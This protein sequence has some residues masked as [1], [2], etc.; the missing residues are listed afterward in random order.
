MSSANFR[1]QV[2]FGIGASEVPAPDVEDCELFHEDLFHKKLLDLA[3]HPF[4]TTCCP[5][6]ATMATMLKMHVYLHSPQYGYM[7]AY[8]VQ[9]VSIMKKQVVV[10]VPTSE[11]LALT[12]EDVRIGCDMLSEWLSDTNAKDGNLCF[13]SISWTDARSCI[14][15]S[16]DGSP[17]LSVLMS[18]GNLVF[19]DRCHGLE[20]YYGLALSSSYYHLRLYGVRVL[21]D[22][23]VDYLQWC[24]SRSELLSVKNCR[25]S[26]SNLPVTADNAL[27]AIR[28]RIRCYCLQSFVIDSVVDVTILVLGS[29]N[30]ITVWRVMRHGTGDIGQQFGMELL[31][32]RVIDPSM[33]H[34][35]DAPLP[36]ALS[37]HVDCS[38]RSR[39]VEKMSFTLLCSTSGGDVR[40]F[41]I[42]IM[43][44]ASKKLDAAISGPS[45]TLS[46]FHTPIDRLTPSPIDLDHQMSSSAV[47][48]T[49]ISG[50]RSA[51]VVVDM[52]RDCLQLCECIS[53]STADPPA[54]SDHYLHCTTITGWTDLPFS[55]GY[56]RGS[57]S[58]DFD[59]RR[60]EVL[61]SF[62]NGLL[63]HCEFT[64]ILPFDGDS[65]VR[66]SM[67]SL[68]WGEDSIKLSSL[69]FGVSVDPLGL[70]CPYL[71]KV[72]ANLSHSRESQLNL[73]LTKPHC[74]LLFR[75][76]PQIDDHFAGSA[77]L[78]SKVLT[79]V[80]HHS[81]V[82]CFAFL[83][84]AFLSSL[85]RCR[86]VYRECSSPDAAD[87]L[88]H[89]EG[90]HGN[91]KEEAEDS[92]ESDDDAS[93]VHGM[94]EGSDSSSS[95]GDYPGVA[96]KPRKLS[97]SRR[98]VHRIR[99]SGLN[100]LYR[101][102]IE[103]KRP[104]SAS[105]V[106]LSTRNLLVA[107]LAVSQTINTSDQHADEL[108]LQESTE[109][110]S[111]AD[112]TTTRDNSITQ[113]LLYFPSGMPM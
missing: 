105:L 89:S 37:M 78:L 19:L 72:S 62:S 104:D 53:S 12:H 86:A 108:D 77:L 20:S 29:C 8:Q 5:L 11:L 43:M 48:V 91:S 81:S 59:P 93:I 35:V 34:G 51:L 97:A 16:P 60:R 95:V 56:L 28:D 6:T 58:K 80:V 55:R 52:N 15:V 102:F 113:S 17:A 45:S 41:R 26:H 22:P 112:W 27:I 54:T 18:D 67:S 49:A 76:S 71:Q 46:I 13:Q 106:A 79:Y 107:A 47:F 84:L 24:L 75:L 87:D 42:D 85:E 68:K 69:L 9:F 98:K 92:V 64:L 31:D 3:G 10:K 33:E 96:A 109:S 100:S 65:T 103:R 61:V 30:S 83:P 63:Q 1:E 99:I 2:R 40:M 90:I 21:F 7:R 82:E 101:T 50:S 14:L 25:Y 94:K 44:V 4:A 110:V 38:L 36:T 73:A 32:D 23:T 39:S 88:N 74:D 70:V 57:L 111:A 66:Y